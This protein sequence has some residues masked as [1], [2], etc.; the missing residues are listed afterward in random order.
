L[1]L[2]MNITNSAA[3][4]THTKKKFETDK[5]AKFKLKIP[6]ILLSW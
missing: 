6:V 1:K 3:D 4:V 2:G 5:P